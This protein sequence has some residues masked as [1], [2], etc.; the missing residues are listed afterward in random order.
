MRKGDNYRASPCLEF[1]GCYQ[2]I[3]KTEGL[4]VESDAV[5]AE[6]WWRMERKKR[7][8]AVNCSED[9]GKAA[10]EGQGGSDL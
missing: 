7:R 9:A 5:V 6:P 8:I 1:A 4:E 10:A 3:A 2:L